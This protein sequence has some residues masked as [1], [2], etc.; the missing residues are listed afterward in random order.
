MKKIW[1]LI[2]FIF[3]FLTINAQLKLIRTP[4]NKFGFVNAIG[5]TI[6]PPIYDY[7]EPFSEGLA[8]VKQLKGYKLIDTNGR[9][10]DI[11]AL[12][13]NLVFRYD[14]GQY[15]SGMP[16]LIP[17]WECKYLDLTGN[18]A[19]KI[20]YRD[21][22]SFRNNKAKVYKADQYAYINHFGM[23]VENWKQIPDDYRAVKYKGYYGFIN[24]NGK[25]VIDYQYIKAFDFK[26]GIAKVTPDGK[27]WAIINKKGKYISQFYEKINDFDNG[28]AIVKI[29]NYF[30]FINEQGKFLSGWYEQIQ[31]MDS[32]LY[33][34]KK[35]DKF[36]LVSAGYQV[37]KWYD[38][39]E[40][41]NE[42]YWIA[43][44]GDK[45]AFLNKYG[46]YIVGWYNKLW[47]DPRNPE[48]ILVKL[49]DKYGFYNIKNFYISPL[50][51][52]LVFNEGIAMVKSNNKYGFINLFGKQIT[53]IEFDKA[54]PFN[55]AI[56]TIEK[57]DKVAYINTEGKLIIDWI[58]KNV[59]V[60]NPPPGLYVVKVGDKY[61]FQTI[62]G[63]RVIPAIY[64]YA[65]PFS[66]G[67]ALVK[68]EP[69][70]M[71]IDTLGN[72]KP[73]HVYPKD[74]SIRLDWGYRHSN[75]PII[76]TTWKTIAY[77]NPEGKKVL[78][79]P[80]DDAES[81]KGG[82]AK[83]YK[84]DKYNYID[85]K[86]N[87]L[88]EW[89]ELPDNYHVVEHN[90]KFGYIDKNNNLVIPYKFDY[91]YDFKDSIAKV[92]I[93]NK[94]AYINTKGELITDLFDEISNL[95]QGLAI[96]RQG[97]KYALL[98][99]N[100]KTLSQWYDRI[101]PFRD[102]VAR[103]EHNGKYNFINKQGK[104]ISNIWFEDADDFNEGLAKIK[105][106]N[107]WGFINSSGKIIV[108]PHY[109]W[110]SSLVNGIAKVSKNGK[111]TLINNK[112]EQITQWFDRI[113]FFSDG[114][115]VVA[116]NGKWGYIDING[117]IVIP[118]E[119]DRAYAFSNGK[120]MV[121]KGDKI[122]FIDK[123]GQPIN[124]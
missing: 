103:V 80:Y 51:D 104:L 71:L 81:F 34:V 26:N 42:N 7:A 31:Q 40:R 38:N 100:K 83:V 109:D 105:L 85:K 94:W 98:D 97:N 25:L 72:L 13:K 21:A 2:S 23:I 68:F 64:D 60:K 1:I 47:I 43:Q 36:A 58:D 101:Y 15:H 52:S 113:F 123:Q 119:Y 86:G 106:S 14:W 95:E 56:A 27:K 8:L 87:L 50:F 4:N 44:D 33:R 96:V 122:F 79:V 66:E 45:F 118:L 59:I 70:K 121:I 63:R 114:M 41:Y 6:I 3:Y 108:K 57:N 90:G 92:N 55:N 62:N 29:G 75:K 17:V 116:K 37:T 84:G 54:T 10:W 110:A 88:G 93:N 11:F 69:I 78:F 32:L 77:I 46:A 102:N 99:I 24:K 22:E 117:H 61:G 53:N 115:S 28:V 49:N 20:P 18:V 39:I 19:L 89:K 111:Y 112:G 12:K 35:S 48:I 76:I 30:G 74:K 16:L 91:A 73:L 5:D 107:K 124:E 9:M 67:L 82:R 65:E 120:A